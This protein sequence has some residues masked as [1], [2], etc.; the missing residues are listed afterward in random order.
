[1]CAHLISGSL[2]K[3]SSTLCHPVNTDSQCKNTRA[4]LL[5]DGL[6][7]ARLPLDQLLH[8]LDGPLHGVRLAADLDL[9]RLTLREV[10]R[11]DV[12]GPVR[13]SRSG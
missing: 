4:R 13:R 11:Q 9:A 2:Q 5:D 8:H 7:A 3:L 12:Q 6:R 1:M 10:L